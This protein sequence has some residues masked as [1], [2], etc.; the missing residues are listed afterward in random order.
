M[1]WYRAGFAKPDISRKQYFS[2]IKP[3]KSEIK[4]FLLVNPVIYSAT[5][6]INMPTLT[7]CYSLITLH[8]QII[9]AGVGANGI[10][11]CLLLH[12]MSSFR[13]IFAYIDIVFLNFSPVESNN[14]KVVK[15]VWVPFSPLNIC[16]IA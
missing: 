12:N 4:K 8:N 9:F 6:C 5:L 1:F 2:T 13:K 14:Q 3:E 16:F 11:F 10:L 7:T 15:K